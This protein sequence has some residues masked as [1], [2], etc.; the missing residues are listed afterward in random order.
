MLPAARS[1]ILAATISYPFIGNPTVPSWVPF[2][3]PFIMLIATVVIGELVYSRRQ[4]HSLT[5]CL[6]TMVYF[7]LDGVQV[8]SRAPLGGCCGM[9]YK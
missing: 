1:A 7:I 5:D 4:H 6:A 3:I 9:I 8:C 2:A